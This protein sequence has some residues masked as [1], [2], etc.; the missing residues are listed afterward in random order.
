MALLEGDVWYNIF[1]WKLYI[2]TASETPRRDWTTV[3]NAMVIEYAHSQYTDKLWGKV[4]P[5]AGTVR[6]REVI[7]AR[8]TIFAMETVDIS[9]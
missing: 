8:N 7:E 5:S 6:H 9:R 2:I 1:Q 4:L 3:F